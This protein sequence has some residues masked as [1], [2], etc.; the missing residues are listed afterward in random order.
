MDGGKSRSDLYGTV[1]IHRI[2]VDTFPNGLIYSIALCRINNGVKML[3]GPFLY[4]NVISIPSGH[5]RVE[6]GGRGNIFVRRRKCRF[7]RRQFFA[8]TVARITLLTGF[9][10]F[11]SNVA[12]DRRYC[13][14]VHVFKRF[15]N[16]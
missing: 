1:G 4:T 8:A 11:L 3:L 15:T 5:V 13:V 14:S 2:C 7:E 6:G 12:R 9:S 10:H 16:K